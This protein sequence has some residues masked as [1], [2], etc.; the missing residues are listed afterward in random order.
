MFDNQTYKVL[1]TEDSIKSAFK[2]QLPYILNTIRTM[3]YGYDE[4]I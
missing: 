3:G 2:K 1:M 4:N